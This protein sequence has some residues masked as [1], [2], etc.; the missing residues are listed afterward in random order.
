VPDLLQWRGA[1]M[2]RTEFF[3]K[4]KTL[5]TKE[6]LEQRTKSFQTGGN[7]EQMRLFLAVV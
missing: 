5:P 1:A 6:T 7:E 3:P 2:L 4:Y